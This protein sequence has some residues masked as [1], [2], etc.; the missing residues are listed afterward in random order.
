M[1]IYKILIFVVPVLCAAYVAFG[2]ASQFILKK[3][4]KDTVSISTLQETAAEYATEIERDIIS[5]QLSSIADIHNRLC[6]TFV[7][8]VNGDKSSLLKSK[9][10]QELEQF[11]DLT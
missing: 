1:K 6:K 7:C 4:K 10:R 8:Y 2:Y 3:E 5:A 9:K 11:I